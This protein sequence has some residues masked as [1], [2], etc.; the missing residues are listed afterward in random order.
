MRPHHLVLIAGSFAAAAAATATVVHFTGKSAPNSASAAPDVAT[1]SISAR[2]PKA[3]ASDSVAPAPQPVNS[4]P[5]DS[6]LP[7]PDRRAAPARAA[8]TNPNALGVSRTVQIDTT[9]GPGL[10]MSQYRDY[11]F[12]QPG[13]VVLTFDDG[14]WPTTTPAVLAALAAQ[15]TQAVFFPIGKHATWHPEVLKQV[16]ASGNT[17]GSH[18]WSHKNLASRSEQEAEDEIERGISAV[19]MMAGAP[20][21][22][23]F[24]FPQLRQTA[25][26]KAY[27]AQRNITAFSIDIDSEDF[28]VHK[29]DVLVTSLMEKLK[30]K[31][32]GIILMHDLHK[33]TAAAV[34]TVL[35]QLKAGGYKVVNI[36]AKDTLATL[37]QYD[38]MI[39][40]E[41]APKTASSNGRPMSS[42]V[43]NVD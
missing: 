5:A 27:L 2:W 30:K 6:A 7:A 42:V 8:C 14:P 12:L 16:I 11:D 34:P 19:S 43:Q 10:G 31:G 23:F 3:D 29:P 35:E 39:G 17:V 1:G 26:L 25:G 32:K 20:I 40:D 21:A 33:W 38:K 18:T 41:M 28:R 4:R 37:P 13:E 36:K 22:P 24:R 15:C 9:G